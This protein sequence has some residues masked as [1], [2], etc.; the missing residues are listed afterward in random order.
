[1]AKINI[2]AH[3]GK[4]YGLL[5]I[6]SEC[7]NIT[8]SKGTKC[9][10]AQC[11]CGVIKKYRLYKILSGHT[12]SCGCY[13]IRNIKITNITHGLSKHPLYKIY[14]SII[15]RCTNP[16][17]TVYKNYGAR[18]ISIC[19]EWQNDFMIFYNWAIENGWKKG[20]EVDR[21]PNR[22][23]DYHPS[24]C[25]IANDKTQANNT[26]RNKYFIIDGETL[27]MSQVA[28]KYGINYYLLRKRISMG[29]ELK[30][31]IYTPSRK[32]KNHSCS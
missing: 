28:I 7:E 25:R 30:K 24:N 27:T 6:L 23:G 19:K 1:M 12:T 26:N 11:D 32:N 8:K 16:N 5:S 15:Q 22:D 14:N 17:S 13:S 3:I 18:G 20:L 10:L 9:V 31:A 21:F 4:K 29:W 2:I